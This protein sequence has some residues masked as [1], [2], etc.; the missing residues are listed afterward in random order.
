[1]LPQLGRQLGRVC[2]RHRYG[3]I[4]QG[5]CQRWVEGVEVLSCWCG[6]GYGGGPGSGRVCRGVETVD[7]CT[8]LW[9]RRLV[10]RRG[11]GSV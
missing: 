1:M 6:G 10:F 11:V 9:P 8:A 5:A 3:G 4:R 2:T 7:G